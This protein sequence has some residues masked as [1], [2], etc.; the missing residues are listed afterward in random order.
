M[1]SETR[2]DVA[3]EDVDDVAMEE[4][5]VAM[6]EDDDDDGGTLKIY[7]NLAKGFVHH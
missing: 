7:F 6:E 4:D 1:L 5:D 2:E 3:M